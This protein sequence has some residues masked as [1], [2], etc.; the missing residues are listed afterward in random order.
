MDPW[1]RGGPMRVPGGLSAGSI[2]AE[3]T[4]PCRSSV[5]FLGL[6]AR[7]DDT[8]GP[9]PAASPDLPFRRPLTP[10]RG[11]R[12][13]RGRVRGGC[14]TPGP[15]APAVTGARRRT[16]HRD[17]ATLARQRVRARDRIGPR[18]GRAGDPADP[19]AARRPAGAPARARLEG[20]AAPVGPQP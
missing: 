17:A 9:D 3:G 13:S 11:R 4:G 1:V 20:A 2:R 12:M 7:S 14:Y 6:R 18:R 5:P 10:V 8:S 19:R 15:N 16:P